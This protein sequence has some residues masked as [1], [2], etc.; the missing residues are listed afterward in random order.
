MKK[1]L[2]LLL[3]LT[4]ALTLLPAAVFAAGKSGT[5]DDGLSW[6]ISNGTLTIS[7][8]GAMQDYTESY[9]MDSV[10][11][12]SEAPWA[13]FSNDYT[14]LV[15]E[16]GVTSIGKNAFR[17]LGLARVK[18][19]DG[20]T[21]IGEYAF[22]DQALTEINL[23]RGL[24]TVDR[25]AFGGTALEKIT[26]PG[27]ITSIG[28]YA[29]SH[30]DALKEVVFE[31]GIRTI[32]EG[33]FCSNYYLET[34]TIPSSVTKVET[35]TF[36]DCISL[37]DIYYGGTKAD[38]AVLAATFD[39][40]TASRMNR[41]AIHYVDRR[42]NVRAELNASNQPVVTWNAVDG[43]AKYQV[44]RAVGENGA[45]SRIYTTKGL[46]CTNTL[47]VEPGTTYF[48]KVRALDSSGKA[49]AFSSVVSVT[50][51]T[52]APF[53]VQVQ[54]NTS[55]RPVVTWKAVTGA[56][57]YQV[58]RAVGENG[59]Y[60]RIYTTTGLKC[61]N[62]RNVEP[63]TTYYYKVR[64]VYESGKT[65]PFSKVVSAMAKTAAP[66]GVQVK[67]DSQEHPVVT[68]NAA[69]GAVKYQVYRAAGENGAY[70]RIYTTKGLKCTNT[71]NVEPDT[72]YF[73]KVRA[74]D[75]HGNV[76]DFSPVVKVMVP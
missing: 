50:V 45:Y 65:G 15:V 55:G 36:S 75:E 21:A 46:K 72:T 51:K 35:G 33:S 41:A 69:D 6:K 59:A 24:R 49:G 48:Y 42:L 3:A 20:L 8:K 32:N 12:K 10:Y 27:T 71:L 13:E 39:E 37:K 19:S 11:S 31:S 73:Y 25:N 34:L 30:I 18:L 66:T 74:M 67:L 47:N 23:P 52:A 60:S 68:W 54:V 38:W 44:Y 61:T 9:T 56:A 28:I 64:A 63:G 2:A 29:F 70:S 14:A 16:K 5:T 57:K 4:M 26:I 53:G 7:G 17:G 40:N 58:Y 43:A 76:S 1:L 62:T 22:T